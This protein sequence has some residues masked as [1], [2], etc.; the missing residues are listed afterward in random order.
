MSLSSFL[1]YFLSF[2]FTF[3]FHFFTSSSYHSSFRYALNSQLPYFSGFPFF[4]HVLPSSFTFIS[5]PSVVYLFIIFITLLFFTHSILSI[6]PPFL[7]YVHPSSFASIPLLSLLHRLLFLPAFT[8]SVRSLLF[9]L[10]AVMC[11]PSVSVHCYSLVQSL[12]F[13]AAVGAWLATLNLNE[14]QGKKESERDSETKRAR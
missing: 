3:F 8:H 6:L 9:S 10:L 14:N 7:Y 4:T 13:K 1:T 12:A 11:R 2:S 5:F